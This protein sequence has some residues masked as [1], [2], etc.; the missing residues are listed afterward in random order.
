MSNEGIANIK[1]ICINMANDLNLSILSAAAP[2]DNSG[3]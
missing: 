2:V 1:P 3:W